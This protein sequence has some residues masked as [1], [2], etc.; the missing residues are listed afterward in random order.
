LAHLQSKP[1]LEK[2]HG[3][4][5]GTLRCAVL[6]PT[7]LLIRLDGALIGGQRTLNG[8]GR[9]GPM[10]PTLP[11]CV[12]PVCVELRERQRPMWLLYNIAARTCKAGIAA[13]PGRTA[14]HGSNGPR[15]GLGTGMSA[16][17]AGRVRRSVPFLY[18][19]VSGFLNR[20]DAWGPACARRLRVLDDFGT[21]HVRWQGF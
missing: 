13:I 7:P 10:K 17:L 3:V 16:G 12:P 15:G 19:V 8:L 6:H 1:A 20:V 11:P 9:L 21:Q 5:L 18:A 2:W 4:R 14:G